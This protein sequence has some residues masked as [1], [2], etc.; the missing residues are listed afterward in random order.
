[1]ERDPLHAVGSMSRASVAR[2]RRRGA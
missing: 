1:V 2:R